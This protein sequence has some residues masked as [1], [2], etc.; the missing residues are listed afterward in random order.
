MNGLEPLREAVVGG[1][2]AAA[3]ATT[4]H[5][6]DGQASAPQ[7][8]SEALLPAM[9]IHVVDLGVAVP[10]QRFVAAARET[11]TPLLALSAL[12]STTV[13]AMR[14]VILALAAGARLARKLMLER[15]SIAS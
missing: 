12:L 1:D 10:P 7:I 14:D 15:T 5:L 3:V 2:V 9:E 11:S 8:L 13:L 4:G 6:L